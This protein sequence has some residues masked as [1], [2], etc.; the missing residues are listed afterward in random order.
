MM[1]D[2]FALVLGGITIGGALM[3]I[4]RYWRDSL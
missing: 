1:L 3:A 2:Q 4:Y